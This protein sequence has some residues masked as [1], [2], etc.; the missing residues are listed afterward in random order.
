LK[1]GTI[2]A[3]DRY[4]RVADVQFEAEVRRGVPYFWMDAL[5]E[6][7]RGQILA[8]LHQG[9]IE[10]RQL[11]TDE[12]GRPVQIPGGQ[13]HHWSGIVFLPGISLERAQ[14]LL[15]D[16]NNYWD[17]YKPEIRRS[18][19]LEH[20]NNTCKISFQFYK[21]SPVHLAFN[22]EFEV[23]NIQIDATHA[24]SRAASVRVAELKHA[25]QPD[26]PEITVGQGNGYVWRMNF[27]WRLKEKD[28]GVYVELESI[29]LSRDVPPIFALF[30]NPLVHRVSRQTVASFLNATQRGLHVDPPR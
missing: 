14:S 23:Q 22:A 26:G 7:N 16:Y 29:V 25:D 10:I 5:P 6:P 1:Q 17:T 28:G 9:Q 19:I 13:I 2:D 18:K 15:F 11:R 27:F 4:V 12:D 8:R 21:E 24:V 20:A 3:F 30:I